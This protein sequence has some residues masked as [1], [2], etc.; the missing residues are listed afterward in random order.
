MSGNKDN[1]NKEEIK[2]FFN[3]KKSGVSSQQ[4]SNL[5]S[6][7][8]SKKGSQDFNK[9]NKQIS[10]EEIEFEVSKEE[11][12]DNKLKN[13]IK[14]SNDPQKFNKDLECSHKMLIEL[15]KILKFI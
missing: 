6:P 15:N 9:H 5:E 10:Q 13:F 3:K 8:K 7:Q 14:N 12:D 1:K 2:D 4:S 11:K